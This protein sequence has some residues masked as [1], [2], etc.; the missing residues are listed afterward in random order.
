MINIK[1]KVDDFLTIQNKIIKLNKSKVFYQKTIMDTNNDLKISNKFLNF[2]IFSSIYS[3]L[4]LILLSFL[5]LGSF[6]V[7]IGLFFSVSL[8]NIIAFTS[9]F[10][11][12]KN[13]FNSFVQL[14]ET[15]M[16]FTLF[17]I[18][19]IFYPITLPAL[20]LF[21]LTRFIHILI[22]KFLNENNIK[23]EKNIKLI[24]I[25]LKKL[26][27]EKTLLIDFFM[28][29]NKALT[30][31]NDNPTYYIVKKEIEASIRENYI[32]NIDVFKFQIERNNKISIKQI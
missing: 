30:F 10:L 9:L 16:V 18:V 20:C 2:T 23:H 12:G 26:I 6:K 31:L 4:I 21:T 29:N 24:N 32:K 8:F 3:I 13:R 17:F 28:K 19:P 11:C 22:M 7:S 1:N 5:F 14:K 15:E 27:D 25:E